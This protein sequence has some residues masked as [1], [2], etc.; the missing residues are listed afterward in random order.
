[1]AILG[2]KDI[3]LWCFEDLEIFDIGTWESMQGALTYGHQSRL[4]RR[5]RVAQA[6]REFDLSQSV[7]SGWIEEVR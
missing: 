4:C 2:F 5:S 1:M 7:S 6:A 3:F